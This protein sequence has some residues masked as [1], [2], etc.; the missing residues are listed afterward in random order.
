MAFRGLTQTLWL[1]VTVISVAHARWRLFPAFQMS[2]CAAF[3]ACP[4]LLTVCVW[5]G[6]NLP[7][8]FPHPLSHTLPLFQEPVRWYSTL[9]VR[10]AYLSGLT[11]PDAD[12]RF[13]FCSSRAGEKI[14]LRERKVWG[15]KQ[16]KAA[17]SLRNE[18]KRWKE[19]GGEETDTFH[20]FPSNFGVSCFVTFSWLHVELS[21]FSTNLHKG[22]GINWTCRGLFWWKRRIYR[23]ESGTGVNYL[24][25]SEGTSTSQVS[26][27][28]C[29]EPYLL[30]FF[31]LI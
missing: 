1:V 23:R 31:N 20:F 5:S 11:C 25:M 27:R 24:I 16:V 8:F 19:E 28:C 12:I 7:C 26:P 9:P 14:R 4:P 21:R 13:S 3:V 2:T 15:R 30:I 22:S 10:V 17:Y 6:Y 29:N 18:K